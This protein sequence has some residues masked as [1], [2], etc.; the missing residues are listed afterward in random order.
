MIIDTRHGNVVEWMRFTNESEL[1][2]VAAIPLTRCPTAIVVILSASLVFLLLL[3]PTNRSQGMEANMRRDLRVQIA[4]LDAATQI[5]LMIVPLGLQFR[6]RVDATGLPR[7]A[8]VYRIDEESG[9]K[10]VISILSDGIFEGRSDDPIYRDSRVGIVFKRSSDVIGELYF[11]ELDVGGGIPGILDH[12]QVRIRADTLAR[13]RALPGHVN[14]KLIASN[15][16]VC[17]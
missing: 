6:F 7:I 4:A 8:C 2:D 3:V 12:Q 15:N 1:F 11:F 13:I 9:K 5:T 17:K 14:A 10:E 16:H